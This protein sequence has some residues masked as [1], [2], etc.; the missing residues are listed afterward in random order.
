MK[1]KHLYSLEHALETLHQLLLLLCI[2]TTNDIYDACIL[3]KFVD[4]LV[5]GLPTDRFYVFIILRLLLCV[6]FDAHCG[7]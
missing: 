1:K 3:I 5:Y 7:L 4:S 2:C 6:H